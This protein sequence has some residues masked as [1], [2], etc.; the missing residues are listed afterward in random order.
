MEEE[1]SHERDRINLKAQIKGDQVQ[2]F[3]RLKEHHGVSAD[4]ELVRILINNEYR[5]LFEMES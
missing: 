3:D 4:A 1:D 5:R 2:K